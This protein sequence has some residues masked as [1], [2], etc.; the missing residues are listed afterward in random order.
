VLALNQIN[1]NSPKGL[2]W[3]RH[4]LAAILDGQSP[5]LIA[6]SKRGQTHEPEVPVRVREWI[7]PALRVA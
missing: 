7:S 1:A 4:E 3:R 6:L 5:N 2:F